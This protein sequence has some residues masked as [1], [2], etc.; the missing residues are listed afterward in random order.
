LEGNKRTKANHHFIIQQMKPKSILKFAGLFFLA[1]MVA[2]T[3]G[4]VSSKKFKL[5]ET[6]RIAGQELAAKRANQI[7]ELEKEVAQLK[8]DTTDL[9]NRLRTCLAQ[10][11]SL[12]KFN[13]ETQKKLAAEL[14]AKQKE[15]D[16]KEA[17]LRD[18]EN[19]LAS[20]TQRLSELQDMIDRQNELVN[21]LRNSIADAL[22][23]FKADELTVEMRNGKVYV[24]LS[25][26]LLFKSGSADVDQ[27]GKEAL[28]KLA[29]VLK[30]KSDIFVE[31]E[32]HTD[33]VPIKTAKFADNWDLSAGRATAITRILISS[34]LPA[35]RITASGRGEFH[36][37][38][39]NE[40]SE[41]RSLN[42][43]TEIILSPKLDE[44]YRLLER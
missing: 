22:I 38:A 25:E 23:N 44:L 41:G 12:Q 26:K 42:R 4:C 13:T 3:S 31:V 29:T 19:A 21:G 14:E 17:Q 36:P 39:T 37:V 34:G 24:S 30:E 43:R 40:T 11:E 18:K 20:Q 35:D 27:K 1:L 6:Q 5:S 9:G 8:S 10:K 16:R 32:G 2:N 15:I 7:R 33:N 28:V